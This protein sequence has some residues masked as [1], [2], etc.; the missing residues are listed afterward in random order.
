M[1]KKQFSLIYNENNVSIVRYCNQKDDWLTLLQYSLIVVFRYKTDIWNLE[2]F[3][4]WDIGIS[5][6]A[7]PGH[8]HAQKARIASLKIL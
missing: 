5:P 7:P 8:L 4:S 6:G 1:K 2:Y 3:E